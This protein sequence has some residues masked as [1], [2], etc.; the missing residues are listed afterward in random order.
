MYCQYFPSY[1]IFYLLQNIPADTQ[2]LIFQGK[3]LQ[4]EKLLREY[5]NT[6][7]IPFNPVVLKRV[8]TP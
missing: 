5:G 7:Y 1:N 2:R 3:V 6:L 8:K 4:D